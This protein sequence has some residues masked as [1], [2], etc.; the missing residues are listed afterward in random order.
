M[1]IRNAGGCVPPDAVRDLAFICYM[2]EAMSTGTGPLFEVAVIHHTQC[3]TGFLPTRDS[4][5]LRRAHRDH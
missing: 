3:G 4:A 1:V 5:R 2:T